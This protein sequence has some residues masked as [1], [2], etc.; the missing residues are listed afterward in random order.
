MIQPWVEAR[1]YTT[2]RWLSVV[3]NTLGFTLMFNSLMHIMSS[4]TREASD[5]V[6]TYSFFFVLIFPTFWYALPL[7]LYLRRVIEKRPPPIHCL[8]FC[9][10]N[11]LLWVP[12]LLVLPFIPIYIFPLLLTLVSVCVTWLSAPTAAWRK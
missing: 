8:I 9:L 12:L 7:L 11:A 3:A 2:F 5:F 10:S 4:Y 1:P 6:T